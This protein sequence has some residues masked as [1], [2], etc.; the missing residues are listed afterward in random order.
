M[1]ESSAEDETNGSYAKIAGGVAGFGPELGPEKIKQ[2]T[3]RSQALQSSADFKRTIEA[4]KSGDVAGFE[5][6]FQEMIEKMTEVWLPGFEL[7]FPLSF[8]AMTQI[9]RALRATLILMALD[10][11]HPLTL[12]ARAWRGDKQAV[13]GLVRA[14]KLFLQ[15][16]CTQAA[17]RDAGLQ[18]D[19][20]FMNELAHAQRFQ[21]RLGRRDLLHI[22]FDLLFLLEEL[23][24]TLP[25]I[26]ELQRLLDPHGNIY[27]GLYAFE[28][29]LQRRRKHFIKLMTDAY[30][31]LPAILSL[32]ASD[33]PGGG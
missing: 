2:Q 4:G 3:A 5:A 21:A 16:R 27:E 22:Y 25:R 15:D 1:R 14:D 19:Q 12:I 28:R 20:Q 11:V 26:D 33:L 24:Q 29:D 32:Y 17:I 18:N 9:S 7:P 13:L 23:G 8:N 10:R 6:G 31:E 30:R